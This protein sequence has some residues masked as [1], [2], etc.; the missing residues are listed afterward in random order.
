MIKYPSLTSNEPS[1]AA[2]AHHQG[3][4]RSACGGDAAIQVPH[5]AP[6]R[7][8]LIWRWYATARKKFCMEDTVLQRR[9]T[10]GDA[11]L[12]QTDGPVQTDKS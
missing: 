8:A 5:R 10:R 2:Q 3:V 11:S 9:D 6:R 1:S 7:F 4:A 12:I